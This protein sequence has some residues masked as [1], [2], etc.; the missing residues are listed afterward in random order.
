MSINIRNA[1][2][3]APENASAIRLT[4]SDQSEYWEIQ[5]DSNG[6][7]NFYRQ[8]NGTTLDRAVTLQADG[9]LILEGQDVGDSPGVFIREEGGNQ[10]AAVFW[11]D[12]TSTLTVDATVANSDILLS[13]NGTGH[14]IVFTDKD[15]ADDSPDLEIS[16]FQPNILF[17]DR[18]GSAKD[19]HLGVNR[20]V[21]F[22][23]AEGADQLTSLWL[24]VNR[25]GDSD[26][27]TELYL[28]HDGDH[29]NLSSRLKFSEVF[30]AGLWSAVD[31]AQIEYSQTDNWLKI[32]TLTGNDGIV[33]NTAGTG[34]VSSNARFDNI[35]PSES[36][37]GT[38]STY[39]T[40]SGTDSVD[41]QHGLRIRTYTGQTGAL[42]Y[43]NTSIALTT[44]DDGVE[45]VHLAF[46]TADD[47]WKT[48]GNLTISNT[49]PT[50]T[51]VDTNSGLGEDYRI[52]HGGNVLNFQNVA[53]GQ[54]AFF[55]FESSATDNTGDVFI[56]FKNG[57]DTEPR[58]QIFWSESEQ[59]LRLQSRLP[60]NNVLIIAG[61]DRNNRLFTTANEFIVNGGNIDNGVLY[62]ASLSVEGGSSTGLDGITITTFEP[63]INFD[64]RS[65]FSETPANFS[66]TAQDSK[67]RVYR[68]DFL[69]LLIRNTA[70][71][72]VSSTNGLFVNGTLWTITTLFAGDS[73]NPG[74][75]L[76]EPNG[77][78]G[79]DFATSD[80]ATY[81]TIDHPNEDYFVW[82]YNQAGTS[83]TIR[84]VT[85]AASTLSSPSANYFT[86]A[87]PLNDYYTWWDVDGG[88][89]DPALAGRIGV[90]VDVLSGDS[91]S[92]VATKTRSAITSNVSEVS[93]GGTGQQVDITFDDAGNVPDA[94]ATGGNNLPAAPWAVSIVTQGTGTTSPG[95]FG[96][97]LDGSGRIGIRVP[98]ESTWGAR[99]ITNNIMDNMVR[100]ISLWIDAEP[101]PFTNEFQ[102]DATLIN[103]DNN[104]IQL[105]GSSILFN[106]DNILL[107]DTEFEFNASEVW[108]DDRQSAIDQNS[109][110]FTVA[111]GAGSTGDS[112]DVTLDK[113]GIW[114]V[115]V[116]GSIGPLDGSTAGGGTG[117]VFLR[118]R[119]NAVNITNSEIFVRNQDT[120]EPITIPYSITEFVNSDSTTVVD[121]QGQRD[122]NGASTSTIVSAHFR[123][124]Y[125]GNIT[126]A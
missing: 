9:R 81:F 28:T 45:D 96:G 12:A 25:D 39:A 82:F 18:S 30:T 50:I 8:A 79:T 71:G 37:T 47:N 21:M 54:Q 70:N 126:V 78:D 117:G 115:I 111:V 35:L 5:M 57:A 65:T 89:T 102:R 4:R 2:G 124:L 46:D 44:I 22:M 42:A 123:C 119:R 109:I 64:D 62:G 20:D 68:D 125:L 104:D 56:R 32:E 13:S 33:I 7:I 83:E 99:K 3:A 77:G 122:N 41:G 101:V 97:A 19:Y 100:N 108:H 114:L 61:P 51:F 15:E 58:A 48:D 27:S 24:G 73:N 85:D 14:T 23:A 90:E 29:S 67:L 95:R 93:V 66:V 106:G 75:F 88:G 112:A 52:I 120:N 116:S 53:A 94:E 118:M 59:S 121:V 60:G 26:G 43:L 6:H 86:W 63:A 69:D 105:N 17:R 113:A 84:L 74:R 107:S 92:T 38:N 110:N 11:D 91:A 36:G 55:N 40:F 10:N 72:T 80:P 16:S 34:I 49:S 1:D 31:V 103:I 76:I 98:F 87:T